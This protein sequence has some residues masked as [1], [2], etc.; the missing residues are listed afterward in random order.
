ML[1]IHWISNL[2]WQSRQRT[3]GT[4]TDSQWLNSGSCICRHWHFTSGTQ[5]GWW[6]WWQWRPTATT[7]DRNW[8]PYHQWIWWNPSTMSLSIF[9]KMSCNFSTMIP[10][11]SI[12]NTIWTSMLMPIILAHLCL[13]YYLTSQLHQLKVMFYLHP[14][15]TPIFQQQLSVAPIHWYWFPPA[16]VHIQWRTSECVQQHWHSPA[17]I[18]V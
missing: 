7:F 14:P 1:T 12:N 3:L 11:L 10:L 13:H 18:H 4:S 8:T 5:T 9:Y 2:H 16:L 6:F 17:P 15:L